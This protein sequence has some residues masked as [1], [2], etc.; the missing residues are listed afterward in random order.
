MWRVSAVCGSISPF[1][2]EAHLIRLKKDVA[3]RIGR[4]T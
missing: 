3:G 1:R 2:F 4:L